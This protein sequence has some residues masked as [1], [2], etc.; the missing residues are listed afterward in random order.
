MYSRQKLRK[1]KQRDFLG[2]KLLDPIFSLNERSVVML[3][4]VLSVWRGGV[5]SEHNEVRFYTNSNER[6]IHILIT[7]IKDK[8]EMLL[9]MRTPKEISCN[10]NRD[11]LYN[12]FIILKS[13]FTQWT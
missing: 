8:I 13:I 6:K 12:Q 4:I 2:T 11:Y 1:N 3:S 7:E 9:K 5:S 10:H